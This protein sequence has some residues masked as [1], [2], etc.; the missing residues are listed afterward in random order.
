MTKARSG[1]FRYKPTKVIGSCLPRHR[2][3]E[4]VKFLSYLRCTTSCVRSPMLVESVAVLSINPQ[5]NS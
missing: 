5:V 3:K 4:F 2:A 1:G